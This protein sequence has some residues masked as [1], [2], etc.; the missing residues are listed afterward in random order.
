MAYTT[1]AAEYLCGVGA[2]NDEIDDFFYF[3]STFKDGGKKP[4]LRQPC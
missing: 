1:K 3:G 4:V 2:T